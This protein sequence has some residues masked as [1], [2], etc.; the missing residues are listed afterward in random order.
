MDITNGRWGDYLVAFSDYPVGAE[1]YQIWASPV[2][3]WLF[4]P[5]TK[6]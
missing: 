3:Y 2:A 4:L 6:R 5:V 1:D